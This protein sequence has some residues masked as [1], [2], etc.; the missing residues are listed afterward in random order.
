MQ[1]AQND[2]F[3]EGADT[4]PSMAEDEEELAEMQDRM[5]DDGRVSAPGAWCCCDADDDRDEA[6]AE[7]GEDD[8]AAAVVDCTRSAR[9]GC[10]SRGEVARR[11]ESKKDDGDRAGMADPE[12]KGRVLVKLW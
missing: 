12:K 4:G 11:E 7:D 10:C 1:C 8:E 9:G 3:A 6:E 5:T 2:R